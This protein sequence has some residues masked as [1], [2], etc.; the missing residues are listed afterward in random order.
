MTQMPSDFIGEDLLED[1]LQRATET[2]TQLEALTASEEDASLSAFRRDLHSMKG[3][4]QVYGLQDLATL[5]HRLEDALGQD[6][7][8]T[9]GLRTQS[10]IYLVH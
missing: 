2:L 9:D 1:F 6:S 7:V 4:A 5:C 10:S 3:N 8:W